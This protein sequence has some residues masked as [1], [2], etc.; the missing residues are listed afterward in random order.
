MPKDI[1]VPMVE[2]NFENPPADFSKEIPIT[3]VIMAAI[4]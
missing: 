3:S 1:I 2:C 4:K